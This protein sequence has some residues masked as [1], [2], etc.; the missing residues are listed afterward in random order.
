MAKAEHASRLERLLDKLGR[1]DLF[2]LDDFAFRK[3]DQRSSEWL[4]EIVDQR[5][6]S[7]SIILTSNRAM[8]DW[9]GVFPDPV[10]AG[11]RHL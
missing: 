8:V 7:R 4:Y 3:I 11:A 6:G 1:I 9:M 10:I 2:I 5:Y